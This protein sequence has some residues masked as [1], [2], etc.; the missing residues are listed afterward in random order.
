MNS[1]IVSRCIAAMVGF[2]IAL[3]PFPCRAVDHNNIDE[4]H[5]LSFDDAESLAFGEQAIEISAKTIFPSDQT[6]G[7]EFSLEYLNGF[8]LNS[9][10]SLSLEGSAG[11]RNQTD[12][13]NLELDTVTATY[14]HNF[15]REYDEIP[16]FALRSDVAVATGNNHDGFNFRLRGIASKTVGQYHRLSVNLDLNAATDTET[17]ERSLIPGVILGYAT[18][19]GYPDRFD[20]TF[21]AQ[22]GAS[23]A[24][25]TEN[26]VVI[27][28]GIGIRQQVGLQRVLDVGVEGRIATSGNESQAR[29]ILG[30]SG[31]F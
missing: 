28:T 16:A 27:L 10:L 7:G 19:L 11:G 6:V 8:A 13:T 31:A 3:F 22:V 12:N 17:G 25:K 23:L 24:D 5:P 2:A 4:G 26:G 15:N 9:Y 1:L 29:I 14:F 21:L 20:Q 18:P 30:Y